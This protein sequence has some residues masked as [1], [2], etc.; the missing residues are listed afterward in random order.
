[1]GV[2]VFNAGKQPTWQLYCIVFNRVFPSFYV[3]EMVML[4]VHSTVANYQKINIRE[5][6]R[7]NKEWTIQRNWQH[8]V[9]KTQDEDEQS[10]RHNILCVVHHY[11]QANINNVNKTPK[12]NWR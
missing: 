8:W 9:D 6:R 2:S 5:N 11:A 1:V 4:N 12:N 10:K 3:V 7:G